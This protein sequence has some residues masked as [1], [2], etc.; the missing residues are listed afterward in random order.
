MLHRLV[1]RYFASGAT[2]YYRAATASAG[3]GE[4]DAAIL[5]YRRAIGSNPSFAEAHNDLGVALCATRSFVEARVAYADALA[6][7][8]SFLPAHINLA[9]LLREQFFD[10][11]GAARHYRL[12]LD[13]DPART[14][15]W[16]GLG[17]TLAEQGRVEP[18]VA[19]LEEALRLDPNDNEALQYRLF[20]SNALPAR[21]LEYWYLEH[22]RWAALHAD[23]LA[24]SQHVGRPA[25]DNRIRVGYLSGDFRE[26]ATARF[27]LP[28]LE[29]HDSGQFHIA[30]YSNSPDRDPI[31]ERMR[32]AVARWAQIESLSD[33]DACCLIQSDALDILVDLSAHTRGNRLGVVARQPARLNISYL[34]YLNTTGMRAVDFRISDDIADPP[35]VSDSLHSERLVRLPRSMWCWMPPDD[36]PAESPL[37][38]LSKG[39]ITFG[40][41]NHPLKL[42]D[43]VLGLWARLLTDAP[44]ARMVFAAIPDE[45]TRARVQLPFLQ[46]GIAAYRLG[47]L[48]RLPRHDYWRALQGVD[49]ALDPFP[50]TGGATTL[51]C[52]WMGV[53]VIAL[54]GTCGFARSS[55][56]VLVNA[57]CADCVAATAEEYIAV[58]GRLLQDSGNLARRRASLREMIRSS[59]LMA[60]KPFVENLER[61]YRQLVQNQ[62]ST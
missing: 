44:E 33:E 14:E 6:L 19:S 27:L 11:A 21:D 56:T 35:G 9:H 58:A 16:R 41:F 25:E 42:N 3:R 55:T 46:A 43:Q 54:A 38:V 24:R 53:P 30:C 51:D 60:H 17:L 59:P 2:R 52:L 1:A 4:W 31:T 49:I 37:P 26:H 62:A 22:R 28:I 39:H 36:A 10:Y 47:F 48:P 61:A 50:Y 13:V 32:N 20:I 29:H 45:E 23:R 7:R 57:G 5:S 18:A 15:A 34:G 12:A 40:S 8:N